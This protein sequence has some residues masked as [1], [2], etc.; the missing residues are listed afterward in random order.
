M[1]ESAAEV[2][3]PVT[4]GVLIIMLV[5]VPILSLEGI[6]GKLYHPMA[7][8]VLMALGASLLVA[9]LLVPVLGYIFLR[10]PKAGAEGETRV[11]VMLRRLYEPVL[12]FSLRHRLATLA[13]AAILLA[14][15]LLV[16]SRMGADFMPPLDEGD[17]VINL[18]RPSDIGVDAS[19]QKQ[20]ESDRVIA[21]FPEVE[22]IYSRVGTA[23]TAMDA[24][25]VHLSDTFVILKRDVSQ[26]PAAANGRRR[27]KKELYGAIKEALERDAPGQEVSENQPI[28]MRVSEI[29]EGSRAD[30]TLRIYGKDL[31]V[32]TELIEKAIAILEKVPGA[33]AVEM[34]ALTALRKSPVLSARLDYPA[35]ARYGLNIHQVNDLLEAAMAGK[36]VGS[37]YEQQ[38]RF[39]IVLKV[40]EKQRE[41]I[42]TIKSLP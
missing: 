9:V 16:Y 39:P 2:V 32:L 28:E 3:K 20:M 42:E 17:I 18:T 5:Y 13:P 30:V 14:L 34:D 37:F 6:E 21:K 12:D 25:G 31:A 38:W 36:E 10:P 7:V 35:I 15:A 24:M 33:E 19:I 8:T 40:A 23:E 22:S 41:D 1:L 26:W 27:T 4:F 29:L 11:F